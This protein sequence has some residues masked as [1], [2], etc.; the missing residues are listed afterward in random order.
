M[1]RRGGSYYDENDGAEEQQVGDPGR[2]QRLPLALRQALPLLQ[3]QVDEGEEH[4]VE[5]RLQVE[6]ESPYGA[7][8]R[9][10][11]RGETENTLTK[12]SSFHRNHHS[13]MLPFSSKNLEMG[14]TEKMLSKNSWGR[15]RRRRSHGR[16]NFGHHEEL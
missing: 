7:G 12:R 5:H 8:M 2:E 1:K 11:R 13:W 9:R 6:A 15:T 4:A 16:R 10:N 3:D 14:H